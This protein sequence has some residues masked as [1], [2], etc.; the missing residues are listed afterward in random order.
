MQLLIADR[1]L[2][3]PDIQ[4]CVRGKL[5]GKEAELFRSN[6]GFFA[7]H[8][9]FILKMLLRTIATLEAQIETLLTSRFVV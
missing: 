7:G 3:L 1:E 4:A 9:R 5:K 6:Q 2:T 8:H